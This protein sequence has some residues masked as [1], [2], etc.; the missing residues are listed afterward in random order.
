MR[1]FV[2]GILLSVGSAPTLPSTP[3]LALTAGTNSVTAAI[4]GDAGVTHYL[5]YKA[6]SDISWLA[7]GNRS[8]DGDITVSGLSNDVPYIFIVYSQKTTGIVSLP[9]LAVVATLSSSADNAFDEL[10]SGRVTD[11]LD[12]FGEPVTYMP[13]GAGVREIVAIVDREAPAELEGMPGAHAT[14]TLVHVANDSTLGISSSEVNVSQDKIQLSVRIDETDKQKLIVKI[15]E[16]DAGMML[17][18]VR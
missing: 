6:S 5:K 7:G 10:L 17:L 4:T 12:E 16:Q 8:G 1:N 2:A 14:R 3:T 15:I 11:F 18:E 9:S 13:S